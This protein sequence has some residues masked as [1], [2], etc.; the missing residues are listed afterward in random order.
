M[1]FATVDSDGELYSAFGETIEECIEYLTA[2][3]SFNFDDVIFYRG[4]PIIVRA[5]TRY[6]E[7]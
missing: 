3:C 6:F 4:E 7:E 1:I 2:L 5:E